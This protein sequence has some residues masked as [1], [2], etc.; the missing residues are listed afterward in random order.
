MDPAQEVRP[1]QRTGWLESMRPRCDVC[2]NRLGA[3]AFYFEEGLDLPDPR[4]TWT[5]CADCN[6]ALTRQLE[7]PA[8]STPMR[9]RV[10]M[11]V[12][13]SERAT[14]EVINARQPDP[15][16][17]QRAERRTEHLLIWLFVI[18]FAVHALVFILVLAEIA[19]R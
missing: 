3:P 2:G 17:E 6:Q 18:L 15:A 19:A 14:P 12:V 13:A 1:R 8:V 16:T 4:Q 9:L 10:A 5:I 11:G 7:S